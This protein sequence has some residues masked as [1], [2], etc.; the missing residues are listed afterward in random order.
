MISLSD[1][2]IDPVDVYDGYKC[3]EVTVQPC[4][5]TA[6]RCLARVGQFESK[7]S[8]NST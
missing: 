6:N 1:G 4:E 3:V 7:T 5:P 2:F 8:I